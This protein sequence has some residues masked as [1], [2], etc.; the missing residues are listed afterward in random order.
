MARVLFIEPFY[1][2]SHRAFADGLARHSRHDIELLTLA[3]GEWRRRM[4]RGAQELAAQAM[5]L[6]GHFDALVATDMLD[7]ATFLSLTRRRFGSTP[8]LLYMHEN[9]FTYPRLRGTKLNSWFGQINYLSALAADRVAFN[10]EYHR[11]DFLAA[12]SALAEQ[13]NNWLASDAIGA[14]AAKSEV[15]P[16]GVELPWLDECR[17]SRVASD[18]GPPLILWNARWEFDKAPEVFAR[19]LTRLAEDG[20]EFRVALA[21]DPGVNPSPAFAEL[22]RA[23]GGRVVHAGRVQGQA[24]YAAL[25]WESDIVVSTARH[26]FF[27]VGMVEAMYCGCFPVAPA[28]FNYPSLIPDEWHGRT[29]YE[30]AGELVEQLRAALHDRP[31]PALAALR[32]SA[33]RFAWERVAPAWD[34]A[35][36]TLA[37]SGG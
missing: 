29:L 2:G 16:V 11:N 20:E 8:T 18:D 23:L 30:D 34:A 25:L 4:R 12:L 24:G 35:I 21:G 1:G 27:G 19:A 6:R 28:R 32:E 31:A 13:P 26:E 5:E 36:D 9:Q 10:S 7:L 15:L 3:E 22:R 14:I 17:P 37:G 33:A